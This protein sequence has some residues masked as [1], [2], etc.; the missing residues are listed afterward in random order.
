MPK[1]NRQPSRSPSVATP[2]PRRLRDLIA[3]KQLDF[4]HCG[5][6]ALDFG[7]YVVWD[8]PD[9]T[10]RLLAAQASLKLRGLRF[11]VEHVKSQNIR[12]VPTCFELRAGGSF[13]VRVAPFQR[14]GR[15]H[16]SV[17]VRSTAI[18]GTAIG[19]VFK[20]MRELARHLGGSIQSISISRIDIHYDV[21]GISVASLKE[22]D[23]LGFMTTRAKR[24]EVAEKN[25]PATLYWNNGM[26]G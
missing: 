13:L 9:R 18:S 26:G 7:L 21:A 1:A 12:Q 10:V 16:I 19:S 5:L 17:Q 15:P 22:L 2:L 20:R 8:D 4:L 25:G 23:D 24:K 6:D 11:A 3:R 14:E